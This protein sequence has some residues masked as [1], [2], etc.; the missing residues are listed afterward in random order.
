MF[1]FV[2]HIQ[3]LGSMADE[4]SIIKKRPAAAM[5]W[6]EHDQA[7]VTIP[8]KGIP[9]IHVGSEAEEVPDGS[10][11]SRQTSRAQRY[12]FENNR[13]SVAQDF[14]IYIYI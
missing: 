8:K 12:V 9:S 7:I 6:T 4:G 2:V 14:Y 3:V 11:D 5:H 1:V 13:A 10:P